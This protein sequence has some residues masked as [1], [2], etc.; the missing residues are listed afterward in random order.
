M[1]VPGA[2]EVEVVDPGLV[3]RIRQHLATAPGHDGSPAGV[4]AAV[5]AALH[6]EGIHLPAARLAPLVRDLADH[7]V[8]L[9]PLESLLRQP[10]VT[11][12]MVNGPRQVWVERHGRLELTAVTF[13]SAEA[14]LQAVRRIVGPLGGRIDRS[15]PFVDAKLP[16]GSRLHAV[17]APIV[18][19]GPLVTVRRFDARLVDWATLTASDTVPADAA[20]LLHQAVTQRLAVV[21]CGRTG[22]GK[23][24]LLQR[25]LSDVDPDDR[26]VLIEDAPE[27]RPR[28][29]HLVRMETRPPSAEGSGAVDI[30]TLV[31]QALRMRPD[32]IIVGEV[33]GIEIADV[34]QALIT[35]HEGCMTTVHASTAAQALIRLEGM[36]L[37][38]GL[39]LA[40]AHAQ[41]AS[42]IDLIVALDRGPAGRRGVVE[43]AEVR[44]EGR[45]PRAIPRWQ[46]R[47]WA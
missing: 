42:A 1:L 22:T 31:R 16:D 11:D 24:T 43:V 14:V 4:R 13:P 3:D 20:A 46:R 5:A 40:A 28:T 32:R 37:Q 34:L 25:L 45:V 9:G 38:A 15:R 41:L 23:T 39:P 29:R 36:A 12:V 18:V 10:G 21:V 8:G 27:L 44:V 26:V 2:G 47:V 17:A 30:A 7:V 6:A 33:R 35:G 19:D